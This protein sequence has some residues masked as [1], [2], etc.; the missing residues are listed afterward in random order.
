MK[1]IFLKSLGAAA[2]VI[3]NVATAEASSTVL[4][5]ETFGN[6]QGDRPFEKVSCGKSQKGAG[7]FHNVDV[8]LPITSFDVLGRETAP[9]NRY[10]IDADNDWYSALFETNKG[11]TISRNT[12]IQEAGGKGNTTPTG[13]IK[14]NAGILIKLDASGKEN[15]NLTFD[16]RIFVG[17]SADRLVAGY[18]V[19]ELEGFNDLREIDLTSGESWADGWTELLRGEEGNNRWSTETFSLDLA[20]NASDVWVAF[21]L[22]KHKHGIGKID[23]ITVTG[24]DIAV[25]PVPA[26]AW[27]FISG[28][29]GLLGMN[30]RNKR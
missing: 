14:N 5:N 23:N 28:L 27:L 11:N 24:E 7:C 6:H 9:A 30:R 2:L 21:W 16:W 13:L 19:G 10:A 22:D 17:Q 18:Y 12:G 25:I 1:T 3:M 4:L 20:D 26:A 29:L 15:L 8:G